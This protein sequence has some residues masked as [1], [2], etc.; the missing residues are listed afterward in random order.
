MPVEPEPTEQLQTT[1]I[2]AIAFGHLAPVRVYFMQSELSALAQPVLF[3]VRR[4][5]RLRSPGWMRGV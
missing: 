1:S 4:S 2:L 3:Q 5:A